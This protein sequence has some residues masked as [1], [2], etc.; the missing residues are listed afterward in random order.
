MTVKAMARLSQE[1]QSLNTDMSEV[2][3]GRDRRITPA[4]PNRA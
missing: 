3:R 4:G 1:P 2:R